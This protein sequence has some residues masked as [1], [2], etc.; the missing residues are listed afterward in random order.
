MAKKFKDTWA[1]RAQKEGFYCLDQGWDDLVNVFRQAENAFENKN[2]KLGRSLFDRALI[3]MQQRM[4]IAC[5][6]EEKPVTVTEKIENRLNVAGHRPARRYPMPNGSAATVKKYPSWSNAA[7]N[8]PACLF[9][10]K[11]MKSCYNS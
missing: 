9:S 1:G 10:T 11:P 7:W 6:K 2:Y 8:P 5:G 4:D 3:Q